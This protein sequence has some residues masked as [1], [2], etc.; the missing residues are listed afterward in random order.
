MLGNLRCA[1]QQESELMFNLRS[2]SWLEDALNW[3]E[4]KTDSCIHGTLRPTYYTVY[5]HS[6]HTHNSQPEVFYEG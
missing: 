6:E 2:E 1:F 4:V 5:K 3:L